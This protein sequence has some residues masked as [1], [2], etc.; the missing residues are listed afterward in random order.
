MSFF[1]SGLFWFIEGILACLVVL[2]FKTWMEDRGTSMPWWKWIL[3]GLWV[4]FLG[5]TIAFI[6]TSA[7]ENEMAAAVKGGII[8]GLVTVIFG[9]GLWRLIN[10]APVKTPEAITPAHE[11]S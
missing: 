1:T 7:G 4:G 2:G 6:F 8:F 10:T 5:F 9:V 11:E 3:F